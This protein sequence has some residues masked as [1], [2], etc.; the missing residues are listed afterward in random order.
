MAKISDDVDT[1]EAE[2]EVLLDGGHHAREHITIEQTLDAPAL[3][4][5]GWLWLGL[6][7]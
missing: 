4:H 6:G 7:S 1:D 5:D 2:P 3:P